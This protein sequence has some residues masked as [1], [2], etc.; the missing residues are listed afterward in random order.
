M[1]VSLLAYG[2]GILSSSLLSVAALQY[3]KPVLALSLSGLVLVFSVFRNN[4]IPRLL[5]YSLF[6]S[7]GVGWHGVWASQQL[8]NRLPLE[9]E[10]IDQRILGQVRGIPQR[11]ENFQRFDFFIEQSSVGFRENAIRLDYYGNEKI[12]A[13]QY[14]EFDVRLKQP[15]GFGNIAGFDF[16]AWALQNELAATGYIRSSHELLLRDSRSIRGLVYQ[17]L[18]SLLEN[19]KYSGIVIALTLGHK[20]QIQSEL[21]DLFEQ[22]GT[23]HL[24]VISGLHIG[25]VASLFYLLAKG[26]FLIGFYRL[27]QQQSLCGLFVIGS[28]IFYAYLA[29]FSLSVQR[30]LIMIVVVI[31]SSLWSRK[32]AWELKWC[33]AFALVLSLNPLA[34]MSPGFWFSFL[35]VASLL[36]FAE[37]SSA[38]SESK[39][40]NLVSSQW[41]VWIALLLPLAFWNGQIS[42]ISPLV[43]FVGIPVV[44]FVVVPVSLLLIPLSFISEP[45]A[46]GCLSLIETVLDLLFLSMQAI[47]ES[48]AN[49]GLIPVRLVSSLLFVTL[50]FG[51]LLIMLPVPRHL[52]LF[53]IPLLLP[54]IKPLHMNTRPNEW[55]VDVFDVGQGLSVLVRTENHTLLFDTAAG[56]N[57]HSSIANTE[58]IPSLQ[59]MNIKSLDRL[60]VSHGD[61]DHSGGVHSLYAQLPVKDFFASNSVSFAPLQI[62]PCN[63]DIAWQWDGVQF[64]FLN[65][66]EEYT[67]SNNNSC[68]LK[69]S[70]SEFSV[71]LPGDIE[72]EAEY[73]LSAH[74]RDALASSIL[75]APHH[76]S[77]SSS[78]YAFIKQ[79]EPQYVVYSAAYKSQFGH[80]AP[81]VKKRYFSYGAEPLET[82]PLGMISFT[83][84]EAGQEMKINS[85]RSD[86]PRYWCHQAIA[87]SADKSNYE[88]INRI[89]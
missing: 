7:L 59:A 22:T 62:N 53:S 25:L 1:R 47:A 52:K 66:L 86:N 82:A 45:M 48:A 26:L 83:L 28:T 56:S 23:H 31:L 51:I 55:R 19:S 13:G 16:E 78:S 38:G 29:G 34:G 57:R 10:G 40:Y 88:Q 20:G 44:G 46:L 60:V 71:L 65:G 77:N 49:D 6:F 37:S 84:D 12:H 76:G 21:W 9:L 18:L 81:S 79:V 43:N 41:R 8:N 30:A 50:V 39:I 4:T 89:W 63:S 74:Y 72:R 69:V 5:L 36:L 2:I 33:M 14:W 35:A 54:L 80:P 58:I 17:R 75:I 87:E 68:V 67:D 3:G 15:R 64:Q 27:L 85:F 24:W 70:G 61:N 42:Y 32:I 73:A 11:L